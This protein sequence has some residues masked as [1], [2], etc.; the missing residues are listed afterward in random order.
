MDHEEGDEYDCDV[1]GGTHLVQRGK[2]LEVTG[3]PEGLDPALYVRCPEAG[4]VSLSEPD[5][6][7]DAATDDGNDWP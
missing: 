2:G 1:C 7:G 6:A 3:S 4:F 5:A